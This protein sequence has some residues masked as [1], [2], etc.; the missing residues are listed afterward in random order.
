MSWPLP[1]VR[2][3]PVMVRPEVRIAAFNIPLLMVTSPPRVMF[4][5]GSAGMRKELIVLL[6]GTVP[7]IPA[8]V[9]ILSLLPAVPQLV[10]DVLRRG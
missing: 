8:V 5:P 6:A 1:E 2:E 4:A 3:P 9:P 7:V 10:A